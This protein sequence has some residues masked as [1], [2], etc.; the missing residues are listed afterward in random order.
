MCV[1]SMLD[2]SCLICITVVPMTTVTTL[3]G[4]VCGKVC[5]IIYTTASIAPQTIGPT[6]QHM[7]AHTDTYYFAALLVIHYMRP[8]E[9][10]T[11]R[12]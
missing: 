11:F 2:V 9:N 5:G 7:H 8:L 6:S 3:Q 10:L 4:K 1:L 12:K